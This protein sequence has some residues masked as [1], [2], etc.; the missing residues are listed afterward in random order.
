M[1]RGFR[2]RPLATLKGFIHLSCFCSVA[3]ISKN[4]RHLDSRPTLFLSFLS[5]C[6]LFYIFWINA[7]AEQVAVSIDVVHAPD[8]WPVFI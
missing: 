6:F 2:N 7:G 3:V 5:S 8:G 4:N 1:S